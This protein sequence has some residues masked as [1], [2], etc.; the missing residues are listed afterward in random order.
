MT[1]ITGIGAVDLETEY[2]IQTSTPSEA[3]DFLSS[4]DHE[5]SSI[6]LRLDVENPDEVYG[7]LMA[8]DDWLAT[9]RVPFTPKHALR[10]IEGGK[11]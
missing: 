10:V 3:L 1:I 6:S 4:Y 2:S 11:V 9:R 5:G 7:V 8:L